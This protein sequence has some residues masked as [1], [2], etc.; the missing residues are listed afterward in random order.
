VA[1]AWRFFDLK[2]ICASQSCR[3][4][5]E[6]FD[7]KTEAVARSHNGRHPGAADGI[8]LDFQN[9][10]RLQESSRVK[11]HS[12]LTQFSGPAEDDSRGKTLGGHDSN[13]QIDRQTRPS[14]GVG[15]SQHLT[16]NLC[17]VPICLQ[18]T[19]VQQADSPAILTKIVPKTAMRVTSPLTVN[20]PSIFPQ[21]AVRC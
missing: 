15:G 6:K 11:N 17:P 7:S 1:G 9:I 16:D 5:G 19:K 10:A 8:E 18:I 21:K 14:A 4:R 12:T 20:E 13:R 2:K 3:E